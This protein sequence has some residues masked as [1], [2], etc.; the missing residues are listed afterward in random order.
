[1]KYW[2]AKLL[3]QAEILIIK[4]FG[5]LCGTK[6]NSCFHNLLSTT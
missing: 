5:A 2:C 3:E 4:Y 6:D 1:M